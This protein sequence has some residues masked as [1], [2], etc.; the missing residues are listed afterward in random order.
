MKLDRN[1]AGSHEA[2]TTE[3][4]DDEKTREVA[5]VSAHSEAAAAIGLRQHRGN[6]REA[7]AEPAPR[8]RALETIG[9]TFAPGTIRRPPRRD[10]CR[11]AQGRRHLPFAHEQFAIV[12]SLGLQYGVPFE[13][14]VE[15]FTFTR[16][17]PAGSV[18]GN[19]MIK[20]ATSILDCIFRELAISDLGR[21]DLA[22]VP[23]AHGR[24]RGELPGWTLHRRRG[25][26]GA[27][28]PRIFRS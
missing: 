13:K 3:E 2:P 15:A 16:F 4:T 27:N 17:E 14:Y 1:I 28:D 8:R 11:H 18:Q 25:F 23:R 10:Y 22:H 5:N 6:Y 26:P 24:R 20:N 7:P 21:D 19:D 9:Y 12:V